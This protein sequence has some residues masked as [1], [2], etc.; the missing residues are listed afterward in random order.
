MGQKTS[1]SGEKNKS[2]RFR[3]SLLSRRAIVAW[4][5]TGFI[6]PMAYFAW[7]IFGWPAPVRVSYETTRL[8]GPLSADGY[9]DYLKVIRDDLKQTSLHY[10]DH[11]WHVLFQ[12]ED[13]RRVNGNRSGP[14]G[15]RSLV[16]REP[17]EI[18]REELGS[19]AKSIAGREALRVYEE[20]M[21]PRRRHNPYSTSEDPVAVAA[22]AAN[23][24]W[25]Q[26]IEQSCDAAKLP[27]SFPQNS[28]SESEATAGDIGLDL[29][30]YCSQ[31]VDRLLL[32]SMNRAGD[33]GLVD[34]Y[35]DIHLIFRIAR[36]MDGLCFVSTSCA[37]S[38]E[39]KASRAII[40]QILSSPLMTKE[41]CHQIESLPQE[42]T[43]P[44]I[45]RIVDQTERYIRLDLIQGMHLRKFSPVR[46][47]GR[48]AF[49]KSR[50]FWHAVDWNRVLV[51]TNRV[52]DEQLKVLRMAGSRNQTMAAAKHR[53]TLALSHEADVDPDEIPLW[54]ANDPT[55]FLIRQL[56]IESSDIFDPIIMTYCRDLRRRVIQIVAR[57][58]MSRKIHGEFP[59]EL[60]SVLAIDGF[61]EAAPDLLIDPFSGM[62]LG[63]ESSGDAFILFSVGPNGNRD[64]RGIEETSVTSSRLGPVDRINDD[65]IW[66]FPFAK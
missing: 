9:V 55:D 40:V 61:S 33:G 52:F 5:A 10:D 49:A 14:S 25:Y 26:A 35:A 45:L 36:K 16:Y 1:A 12:D 24:Y 34:A 11:P 21:L 13:S 48:L 17:V 32:R 23:A 50:R 46:F 39:T 51:E 37:D 29:H 58:S 63:Y 62:V 20:E 2:R 57:L 6:L 66:R 30:S 60:N 15:A 59:R 19:E 42:S 44:E 27:V 4:I 64:L 31:I 38:A 43:M 54:S 41:C 8:T 56:Q 18:L 53:Q 3:F 47:H 7:H 28:P 22:I 65:L